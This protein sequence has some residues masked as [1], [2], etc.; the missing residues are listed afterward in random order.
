MLASIVATCKLSGLGAGSSL[1]LVAIGHV[2]SA[3]IPPAVGI[4]RKDLRCPNGQDRAGCNVPEGRDLPANRHESDI[5]PA[6]NPET[7]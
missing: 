2:S 5:A 1:V 4:N 7:D 3:A 6:A